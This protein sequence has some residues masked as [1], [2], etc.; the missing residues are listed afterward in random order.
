MNWL[1][2]L[3]RKMGRFA[4]PNLML[5]ISV[6]IAAVFIGDVIFSVQKISLSG[7]LALYTQAALEGQFWR[8][9][10]F[11]SSLTAGTGSRRS[12]QSVPFQ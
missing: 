6:T 5:Y 1:N 10:R 11:A 2:K 3:E 9:R 8:F 7:Y 4:I 12:T